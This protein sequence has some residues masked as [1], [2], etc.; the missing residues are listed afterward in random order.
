MKR[1]EASID[2]VLHH[3]VLCPWSALAES[4]LRIVVEECE[5]AVRLELSPFA[6]RVEERLPS[7][8]EALSAIRAIRKVAKEPEGRGIKPDLWRSGDPPRSSVPPLVAL[9]AAKILGGDAAHSRLLVAM[10][11]AAFRHGVNI[12]RDDV[13]LEL[14]E[15]CGLDVG[16]FA[17]A[18]ASQ[19][20]RRL[21]TSKHEQA[22]F[23]GVRSVPS[24]VIGGEWI[25][26]GARSLEEYR[27]TI[28]RFGEQHALRIP[29]RVVH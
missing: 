13:I 17:T 16:R 28:R 29:D 7:S 23:R 24:L 11:R 15:K 25:V 8:R 5:G 22:S 20:T 26:C 1:H 14:A 10:R 19:A 12:S 21:I 27:E 18:F 2:L 6:I 9:E 4:R 3:D